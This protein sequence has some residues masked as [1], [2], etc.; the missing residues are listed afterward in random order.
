MP[1]AVLLVLAAESYALLVVS[2]LCVLRA[3][4]GASGPKGEKS[5]G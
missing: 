3:G 4:A 2:T 5:D 1:R